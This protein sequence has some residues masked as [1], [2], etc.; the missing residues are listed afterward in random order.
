MFNDSST[1]HLQLQHEKPIKKLYHV[2]TCS[3]R[4]SFCKLDSHLRCSCNLRHKIRL[5]RFLYVCIFVDCI[6]L[7]ESSELRTRTASWERA[8]ASLTTN[9][10]TRAVRRTQVTDFRQ[11]G[12]HF[13]T[14]CAEIMTPAMCLVLFYNLLQENSD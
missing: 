14:F 3:R 2:R 1:P 5:R 12:S 13:N 11:E 4:I 8:K 10:P 9:Y 7:A 6:F